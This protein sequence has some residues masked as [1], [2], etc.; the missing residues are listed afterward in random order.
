MTLLD[1]YVHANNNFKKYF[2]HGTTK[3]LIAT[4]V[5]YTSSTQI[6][7]RT[8]LILMLSLSVSHAYVIPR[9]LVCHNTFVQITFYVTVK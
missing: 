3:C 5:P 2:T 6:F 1:V 9:E 7:K 4:N 8:Y